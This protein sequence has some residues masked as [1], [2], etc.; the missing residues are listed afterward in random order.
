VFRISGP[1]AGP[2]LKTLTGRIPKPRYAAR[3]LVRDADGA[4]IDDG[5]VLWFPGPNSFTGEDVAELQLHGS[6]AV[7]AALSERLAGLG[8]E[9]AEAG[10]FTWRAFRNG[11]LD[12]TEV[13]GLSDLL[14]AETSLQHR[15][16]RNRFS[17]GLREKAEEWRGDLIAAMAQLDAAVDFPDEEDVPETIASGAFPYVRRVKAGLEAVLTEAK[18]AERIA[19]GTTIALIGPP[20]AGKSTIFNTLVKEERAIVSPEAGTTRDVLAAVLEWHGHRVTLLDMAGVREQ[21]SNEIEEEG[22]RRAAKAADDADLL[23]LCYPS[24]AEEL[25][26]WLAEYTRRPHLTVRT[27]AGNGWRDGAVV[28]LAAKERVGTEFLDQ[29][30]GEWLQSFAQPGLA[31]GGR[32]VA[33]LSRAAEI[34]AT[35]E[36]KVRFGPELGSETLRAA[37]TQLESLVGR[38][39]PD[40]I[41]SDIF[42]SF[43]I[44]K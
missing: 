7:E 24:G 10:A 9:A 44:G 3:A 27:M 29:A 36:E 15:Q 22:I 8:C 11:K 42:S 5:I 16:A 43:C 37:T 1:Q 13:E 26:G 17:G 31:H 32:Q 21:A 33:L 30:V 34:L 39:A 2:V 41:L 19:G 35:F 40:D 6:L 14:E 28:H 38:I 23:L 20:N 18:G 25:P 12:L 4:T